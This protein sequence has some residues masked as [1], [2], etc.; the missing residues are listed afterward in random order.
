MVNDGRTF[1]KVAKIWLEIGKRSC[2]ENSSDYDCL[3]EQ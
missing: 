1:L 3:Y 2:D